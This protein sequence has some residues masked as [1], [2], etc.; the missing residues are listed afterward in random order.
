MVKVVAENYSDEFRTSADGIFQQRMRLRF[1]FGLVGAVSMD[2]TIYPGEPW[3]Q[4]FTMSRKIFVVNSVTVGSFIL[5]VLAA[6]VLLPRRLRL[7]SAYTRRRKSIQPAP[8]GSAVAT[9]EYSDLVAI[10]LAGTEAD[11]AAIKVEPRVRIFSWYALILWLVQRFSRVV[12]KP[13][14]THREFVAETRKFLGPLANYLMDFTRMVERL[15]YSKSR[16]TETDVQISEQLGRRL[17]DGL[18]VKK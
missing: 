5:V 18:K 15:L 2:V 9:P 14:Q 8:T 3:N 11:V 13:Q 12:L 6:G 10:P 16:A 17:Q 7:Q 1:E 4:T